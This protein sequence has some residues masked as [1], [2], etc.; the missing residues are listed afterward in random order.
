MRHIKI[1]GCFAALTLMAA[2][3]V[4][5]PGHVKTPGPNANATAKAQAYGKHCADQSKKSV[6]G[7]KSPFSLCVTAMAKVAN[8]KAISPKAACK[9]LSKKHVKG[10]KNTP[11]SKCVHA[12]NELRKAQKA[13]ANPS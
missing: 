5:A 7:K 10:T 13:A 11:F 3:A 8:D 2:P 6:D 9:T 4:A 12:A 1:A